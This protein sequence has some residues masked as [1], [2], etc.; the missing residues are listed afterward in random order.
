MHRRSLRDS[1]V[2]ADFEL[3]CKEALGDEPGAFSMFG[4][5]MVS[6]SENGLRELVKTALLEGYN[7]TLRPDQSDTAQSAEDYYKEQL[8]KTSKSLQQVEDFIKMVR[9]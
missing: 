9:D 6:I 7:S 3:L 2:S 4:G 8:F 5:T 1:L